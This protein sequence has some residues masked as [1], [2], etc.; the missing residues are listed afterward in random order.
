MEPTVQLTLTIPEAA[1]VSLVL[2]RGAR[3]AGKGTEDWHLAVAI[4]AKLAEAERAMPPEPGRVLDL[5]EKGSG[6]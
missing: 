6:N 4:L 2:D 5:T 3:V 1:Y